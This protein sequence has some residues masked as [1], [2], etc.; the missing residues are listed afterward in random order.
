MS[1]HPQTDSR[2]RE[3]FTVHPEILAGGAPY[4]KVAPTDRRPD[5]HAGP[6]G[7]PPAGADDVLEPPGDLSERERTDWYEQQ[8]QEQEGFRDS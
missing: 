6:A 7:A 5:S 2:G 8:A 3:I 1:D 4:R